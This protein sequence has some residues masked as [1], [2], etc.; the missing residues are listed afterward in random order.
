MAACSVWAHIEIILA[1][2]G[3]AA[4]ARAL[5]QLLLKSPVMLDAKISIIV[6]VTDENSAEY[7]ARMAEKA[8]ET[9]FPRADI[10]IKCPKDAPDDTKRMSLLLANRIGA[11][12]A[13]K[14]ETEI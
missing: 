5:Y 10:L 7:A 11:R 8:K 6:E 14:D 1:L 3:A 4:F 2:I 9:Y 13:E 12:Y